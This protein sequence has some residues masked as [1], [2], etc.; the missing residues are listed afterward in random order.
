MVP[1]LD[2]VG[3]VIRTAG[4][5]DLLRVPLGWAQEGRG[6]LMEPGSRL[7]AVLV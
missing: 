2:T 6:G 7:L 3:Q 4:R 5:G 1:N